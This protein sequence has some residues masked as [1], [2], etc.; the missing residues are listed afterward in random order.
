MEGGYSVPLSVFDTK[1]IGD[2]ADWT[3]DML[4]RATDGYP[5]CPNSPDLTSVAFYWYYD[6][7]MMYDMR[8]VMAHLL[9]EADFK[10]WE[11]T[12]QMAVVGIVVVIGVN[13]AFVQGTSALEQ[14]RH[15]QLVRGTIAGNL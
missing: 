8:A 7:P 11:N 6:V 1:Y 12:Y 14:V 5:T 2:L 4:E 10:T 9:S 13:N 3:H 15:N